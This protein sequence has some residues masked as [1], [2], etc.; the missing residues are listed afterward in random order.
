M[1]EEEKTQPKKAWGSN[2]PVIDERRAT[3]LEEARALLEQEF[4]ITAPSGITYKVD[5]LNQ[6]AYARLMAKMEGSDQASISQFVVRNIMVLGKDILPDIIIEPKVGEDGISPDKLPPADINMIV[7]FFIAG[8][9]AV[10][11][12][13]LEEEETFRVE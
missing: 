7:S 9:S 4:L 11:G 12:M 8:P 1:S 6:A 3:S 5:M 2:S 10:R 13:R